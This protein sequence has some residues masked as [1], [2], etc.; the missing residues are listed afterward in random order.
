MPVEN[1]TKELIMKLYRE[2]VCGP[3]LLFLCCSLCHVAALFEV[4]CTY[5]LSSRHASAKIQKQGR[6]ALYAVSQPCILPSKE[7]LRFDSVHAAAS[8]FTLRFFA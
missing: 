5:A 2:T 1:L 4:R 6:H 8:A 3:T 7:V